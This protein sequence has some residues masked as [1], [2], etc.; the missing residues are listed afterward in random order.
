MC[1]TL[2]VRNLSYYFILQTLFPS[3]EK[4]ASGKG[5]KVKH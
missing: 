1:E 3:E 2:N 4:E 5:G